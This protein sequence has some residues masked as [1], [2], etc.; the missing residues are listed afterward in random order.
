M[1][2]SLGPR[3]RLR[4]RGLGGSPLPLVSSS[5]V[6]H[7]QHKSP[8][9]E[10]H[11]LG[12]TLTLFPLAPLELLSLLCPPAWAPSS[13]QVSA[14]APLTLTCSS[15]G[16]HLQ[17]QSP[18]EESHKLGFTLTLCPSGLGPHPMH[19]SP[20]QK[21]PSS[22]AA[23]YPLLPPSHPPTSGP[24]QPRR[25]TPLLGN[26]PPWQPPPPSTWRT[27]RTCSPTLKHPPTDQTNNTPPTDV[28]APG[29][30]NLISCPWYSK[31]DFVPLVITSLFRAPGNH[32]SLSCPW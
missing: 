18:P 5:L 3:L 32:K 17:H 29:T 4:L 23:L 30:L 15:L 13:A 19:K 14:G 20:P 31:S 21:P 8:P 24:H 1:S 28:R 16:P 27:T 26:N 2:S 11:K 22:W 6:P 7:L 12:F 10:S 25:H 9:E